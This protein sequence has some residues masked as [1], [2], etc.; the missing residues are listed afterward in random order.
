V[1]F[2]QVPEHDFGALPAP[3]FAIAIARASRGVVLVLNSARNVWELPGG[4]IDPGESPR[5]AAIRELA[6]E[7]GCVAHHARWLGL[8]EVNDGGAKFG[9]LLYCEVDR[10][11]DGFVSNETLA[12]DLWREDHQPRPIGESDDWLLRKFAGT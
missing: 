11:P 12:V 5:E 6:E 4:F 8:V 9:G 2:H 10:V 3:A 7:A 1:K